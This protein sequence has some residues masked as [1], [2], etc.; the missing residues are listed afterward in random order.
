MI[1]IV[2]VITGLGTG[3]AEMML[4]KLL[5][6]T[7]RDEFSHSVISLTDRGTLGSGIQALG[8]PVSVLGMHRGLPNP[9]DIWRLA[10]MLRR[11][12]PD[13]VQTWMY[14]GDL[15][16]G[17]AARMAGNVP[18]LWGI[19]QSTFDSRRS[20]RRTQLVA[21]LCARLSRWLPAT[22][23]CCSDMGRR[24]HEALGYDARK[25]VVIPNGFDL[26]AFAPDPQARSAV[27]QELGLDREALL[28]GLIARFDP[29][30]DHENF[31]RAAGLLHRHRP[32]VHFVLCGDGIDR[33]NTQLGGWIEAAGIGT[34]CH[35]LGRRRDMARLN[36]ALDVATL[37]SSWGEGFPNVVGEAM[38]CGV[39]C[40]VT[41]VGDSA[42][43]VGESG[44]VVPCRDPEALAAAWQELLDMPVEERRVLGAAARRRI[45][46]RYSLQAVVALYEQL[47]R[48]TAAQGAR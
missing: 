35:L 28:V 22:I 46:E 25:M 37:S 20:R 48:E 43:I 6:S 17:L 39:P 47:Y 3:G 30:K 16:G 7:H 10:K 45:E 19:R 18:V 41:D 26:T 29:Q 31:I 2:H 15:V 23:V 27:R 21:R 8:V 38:A 42:L 9:L 1:K 24:S 36:A 33:E 34:H 13:L 4:Y 32:D 5:S 14:H 12:S 40:A 11:E 44:R